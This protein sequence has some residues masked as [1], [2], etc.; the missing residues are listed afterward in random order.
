[1]ESALLAPPHLLLTNVI[2]PGMNGIELAATIRRVYP[3][4]KVLFFTGRASS[5]ALAAPAAHAGGR[6]AV[7]NKHLPPQALL[8]LVARHLDPASEMPA[9]A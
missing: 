6:F 8:D 4:C 5:Y 9:V 7:L 2:L 3:D 1:M